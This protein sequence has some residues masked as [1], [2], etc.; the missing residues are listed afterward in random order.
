MNPALEKIK[1]LLRLSRDKSASPAEAA[2]ALRKAMEIAV[3][4]GIDLAKVSTDERDNSVTHKTT[5]APFGAAE[6]HAA[7]LIKR[8]FNV[9]SLFAVRSGKRVVH[10][11]G[12]AETC[13]LAVYVFVYL[14]RA[15]KKAWTNRDNKRLKNRKAFIFGFMMGIDELMPPK[16]HQ[17][18]VI[19]SFKAYRDEVLLSG[20]GELIT[21]SAKPKK[22]PSRAV[23]AGYR[24]GKNTG[25]NNAIR[26]T[27]KPLI[28]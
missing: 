10:L 22:T 26:G 18:G 14:V 2:A 11:Y 6:I 20:G 17:P 12:Y 19:P 4:A 15:A 8:H 16:F 23:Y 1:K 21:R 3:A 24:A 9:D 7:T 27:D 25:I 28:S 5:P 13:D